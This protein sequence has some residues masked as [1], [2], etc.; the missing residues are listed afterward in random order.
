MVGGSKGAIVRVYV[1]RHGETQENRDGI[2]Q[3]QRDT[4]LNAIGLE[5]ARMVGEALKDAR[6]G[7]AFSSD[8]GRAVKTAEAILLHHPGISL[9][10]RVELRE[11]VM[12]ELEGQYAGLELGRAPRGMEPFSGMTARAG[13]WWDEAVVPWIKAQGDAELGDGQDATQ[14]Q[15]DVL[16][17]SHGGLI[18]ALLQVLRKGTVRVE[19]KVLLTKCMNA[20]I[21]IIE[22]DSGSA[23][24]TI[25]RYSDVSHLTG[26]VVDDN[27]DVQDALPDA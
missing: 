19:K 3:G 22:L 11:R 6:L 8:L 26:P 17:V 18:G 7:I 5:Q 1:V 27:V 20:S 9:H 24:G 15:R 12:G 16:V 10:K 21:T 23:T 4:S 25:S 14:G 13:S 2:I